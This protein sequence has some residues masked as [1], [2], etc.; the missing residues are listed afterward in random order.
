[1]TVSS[2][3]PGSPADQAGLKV[4]DTITTVDGQKVSKGSELVAD[5]C[6]PETRRE[7]AARISA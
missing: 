1:M 4:G 3:V 7:S 5:I 6:Y 2:V